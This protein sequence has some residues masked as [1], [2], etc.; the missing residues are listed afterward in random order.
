MSR[1][2]FAVYFAPPAGS[3]LSRF[4]ADWLGRDA[5]SDTVLPRPSWCRLDPARAEAITASPRGYGFHAT[6]KAPFVP[7]EGVGGE[8]VQA[9]VAAL[10]ASRQPFDVRLELGVLS[11]FLALVPAEPSPA[12]EALAADCVRELDHLRAPLSEADIA[13]RRK[14]PLTPEED[15]YLLRWGYPYV[16]DR[17]RFHMTLTGRLAE[18]ELG[19]VRAMLE[20]QVA[21]L[22]AEPVRIDALAVFE[23]PD[24]SS[25]FTVTGRHKLGG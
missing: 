4:A 14:S 10:A 16:L 11:G 21:P 19:Q 8:E 5:W 24:R 13:R 23:Q 18:P 7:A 1:R 22:C 25:P 12:L 3:A 9:A 17:F 2:R 6:L 15:A 20:E